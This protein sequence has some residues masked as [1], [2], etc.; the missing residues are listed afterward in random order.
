MECDVKE[1]RT[2]G[3]YLNAAIDGELSE[4]PEAFR[5]DGEDF[6]SCVSPNYEIQISWSREVALTGKGL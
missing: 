2:R 5:R 1:G 4:T 6:N 3:E